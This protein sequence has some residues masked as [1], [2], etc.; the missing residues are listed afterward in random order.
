MSSMP[1]RLA[2]RGYTSTDWQAVRDI[3]LEAFTPIHDGFARV[4][5]TELFSLVYPDW[6]ASNESYLRSLCE[7]DERQRVLVAELDGAVV[8]FIHYEFRREKASGKLGLNAVDPSHQG[9]GI[10]AQMYARVF[11]ILRAEGI[12]FA[13]VGTGGDEAHIPARR[14]Y[15]KSG[16]TPIPVVHYFKKL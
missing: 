15:E 9:S 12:K 14:A 7:T 6:K 1:R 10:A 11:E 16:F 3:C 5:G 2:I 8:G 4:L 13:Q